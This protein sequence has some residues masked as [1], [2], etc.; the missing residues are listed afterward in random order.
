M[1]K[2]ENLLRGRVNRYKFL[3]SVSSF[4]SCC[5]PTGISKINFRA[6]LQHDRHTFHLPEKGSKMLDKKNISIEDGTKE[7]AKYQRGAVSFGI[8]EI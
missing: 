5:G 7:K 8:S 3:S 1:I 2:K 6:L 4:E